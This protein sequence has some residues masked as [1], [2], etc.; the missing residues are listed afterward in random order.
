MKKKILAIILAR[1]GSKRIKNK[2]IK[3]LKNKP[4]IRWTIDRAVKSKKFCD[5]IVSSDSPKILKIAKSN[6]KNILAIK[7]PKKL[8]LDNSSSEDAALHA[9]QWY[10]KKYTKIDY[11]ALLQPTSP[12][13]TLKTIKKCIKEISDTQVKAVISVRKADIKIDQK[14]E[15]FF[16]LDKTK[17]CKKLQFFKSFKSIYVINGIFYL[18][19]K[20]FFIKNFSFKPPIFKPIIVSSRKENID[21]DT[22]KDWQYAKK[23]I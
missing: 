16:Y 4:L 3:K 6:N 23:F 10:E 2:N 1:S 8:S 11:I 22:K 19:K 15:N 20:N 17:F 9:L 7:R 12:F 21:I 13:R 14:K 5:I 18:F